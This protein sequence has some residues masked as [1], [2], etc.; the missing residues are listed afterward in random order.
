[1]FHSLDSFGRRLAKPGF[2]MRR[3]EIPE[4]RTGSISSV[5]KASL[6]IIQ[7]MVSKIVQPFQIVV[8]HHSSSLFSCASLGWLP[9]VLDPS[10]LQVVAGFG[11]RLE[12]L[13]G[14]D[15]GQSFLT[16]FHH[17]VSHGGV[18]SG[19]PARRQN[20]EPDAISC[21]GRRSSSR[22]KRK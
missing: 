4:W 10:G 5:S 3:S 7:Q 20:I 9:G 6:V 18:V 1:M 14:G 16:P 8:P 21:K 13:A 2:S 17:H 19:Y 12:W 15:A 22:K 11:Q